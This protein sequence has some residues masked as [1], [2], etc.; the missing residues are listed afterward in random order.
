MIPIILCGGEGRRLYPLSTKE[1]PKQFLKPDGKHTLLQETALRY[2]AMC[3][4]AP[5]IICNENH[6]ELVQDN[7]LAIN[8][9]PE[10]ILCEPF[11]RNTGPAITA[12][13]ISAT[14][15]RN[16][17]DDPVLLIAPS[18]HVFTKPEN[19]NRAL[20]SAEKL[21]QLGHIVTFGVKPDKPHTGYGYIQRAEELDAGVFK[22]QAFHEKPD[23]DTAQEYLKSGQYFWN[24]GIFC[25][26]ASSF[27]KDIKKHAPQIYTPCEQ[28]VKKAIE[29]D[30]AVLLNVEAFQQTPS[31]SFDHALMEK[32]DLGVVIELDAGWS[33][34]GSLQAFQKYQATLRN[35]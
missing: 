11:A 7:M 15:N 6:F 30:R 20:K 14:L 13:V 2:S 8:L 35:E 22:I 19:F 27:L 5:L 25:F 21:A 18:D 32:T 12:A 24:S 1:R 26:K 28:A 16:I 17:D 10:R 31:I 34:I 9:T 4:Q 23:K 29:Q 3:M 33:D